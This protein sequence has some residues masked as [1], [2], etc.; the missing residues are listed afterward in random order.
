MTKTRNKTMNRKLRYWAIVCAVLVS[1]SAFAWL[2]GDSFYPRLAHEEWL[3]AM[4]KETLL[5]DMAGNNDIL[6]IDGVEYLTAYS[7]LELIRGKQRYHDVYEGMIW[8]GFE[9]LSFAGFWGDKAIKCNRWWKC[10]LEVSDDSLFLMDIKSLQ[11]HGK[12]YVY[13]K[14]ENGFVERYVASV[15]QDSINRRMEEFTDCR[16]EDGRMCLPIVSGTVFAKKRNL[17]PRPEVWDVANQKPEDMRVYLR[18]VDEP[19]YRVVFDEGRMVSM[20]VMN[21]PITEEEQR[22]FV[23]RTAGAAIIVVLL[24]TII[25]VLIDYRRKRK[26]LNMYKALQKNQTQLII[27]NEQSDEEP[28]KRPLTREEVMALYR[29]NFIICREQFLASGWMQRLEKMNASIHADTLT[30][31]PEERQALSKVLD[32]CFIQVNVN[33]RSECRL[34][35][36]DVRCCLLSMLGCQLQVVAV[37]LGSSHDAVQT[38]KSRLKDKLPKDIFEWVFTKK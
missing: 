13:S 7:P 17:A 30:L 6:I 23:R 8:G 37:C 29:D 11:F 9:G 20:E 35:N 28:E 15:N 10:R 2:D 33:L 12:E 25:F 19:V 31:G 14:K 36:D 32:E 3:T 27:A 16:F 5:D 1:A 38:R 34:T 26:Y 24:V 21:E 22:A 18:W 4:D